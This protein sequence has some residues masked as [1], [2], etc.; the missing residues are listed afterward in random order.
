MIKL[1]PFSVSDFD[2]FISWADTEE[3]LTT[4]A[5]SAF[6]YPLT[7]EQLQT[8]LE[9]EN[10]HSFTVVAIQ[11]NQKIGHAEI[12]C[13]GENTFKIDKLIIGERSNRGK[14][15]G[16]AV[17]EELLTYAFT[18]LDAKLVELNVFDWNTAGIRC[19][20]KCGFIFNPAIQTTFE[21]RQQRWIALNMTLDKASWISRTAAG[22]ENF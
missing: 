15:I 19:Y 9:D 6:S 3:L 2:A 21:I 11:T 12:V 13:S 5:G 20:Q 22:S 1:I 10:S 8:Y 14:G 16:Q 4:I 7:N 17:M 18:K